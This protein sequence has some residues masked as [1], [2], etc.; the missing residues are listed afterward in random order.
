MRVGDLV[1][2]R[3]RDG[4]DVN[5]IIVRRVDIEEDSFALSKFYDWWVLVQ[6]E[7][8][9]LPTLVLRAIDE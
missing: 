2:V 4:E 6:G 1:S 3:W 8:V 7:V 5:G 9:A